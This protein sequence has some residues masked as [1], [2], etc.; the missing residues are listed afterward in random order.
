M[1]ETKSSGICKEKKPSR[2]WELDALR[3]IA[4]ILMVLFHLL[5]DLNYFGLMHLS[6]YEGALGAMQKITAGL[7]LFVSG[8]VLAI[9]HKKHEKNFAAYALKRA[10]IIFGAGMVLT[11]ATFFLFPEQIIYFGILHLIGLSAIISFPIIKWK[12]SN[13]L[14]GLFVVSLPFFFNLQNLEIPFLSWIGLAYPSPA[15]DFFP[16]IPWFGAVL[17]GIGTGNIFYNKPELWERTMPKSINAKFVSLL[18]RNSL[19]IY[20]LHQPVFFL[21]IYMALQILP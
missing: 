11:I 20:F 16:V 13:I 17:L 21:I 3:G 7:F 18:G 9:N 10:A 6:L 8:I 2:F 19:L 4:I 12:K 15:L 14:L 5:W 1:N